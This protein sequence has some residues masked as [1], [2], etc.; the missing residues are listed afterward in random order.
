VIAYFFTKGPKKRKRIRKATIS[1]N[2]SNKG[3]KIKNGLD[4]RQSESEEHDGF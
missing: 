2:T 1:S 4:V 3:Q